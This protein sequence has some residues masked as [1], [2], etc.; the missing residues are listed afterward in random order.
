MT[1]KSWT[2]EY[3]LLRSWRMVLLARGPSRMHTTHQSGLFNSGK[4]HSTTRITVRGKR[5]TWSHRRPTILLEQTRW[6]LQYLGFHCLPMNTI[7][8]PPE[9]S[10]LG[11]MATN[12]QL[13]PSSNQITLPQALNTS[14]SLER[15]KNWLKRTLWNGQLSMSK[16]TKILLLLTW[17]NGRA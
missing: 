12:M 13:L 1:P 6:A 8:S 5:R 15:P 3:T 9:P 16:N 14:T 2:T 4:E 11:V 10:K 17:R 7:T